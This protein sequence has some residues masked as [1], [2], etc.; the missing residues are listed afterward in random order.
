MKKKGSDRFRSDPIC[1][2][3]P[4]IEPQSQSIYSGLRL[5]H[6]DSKAR[7]SRLQPM[8]TRGP[9]RVTTQSVT[10]TKPATETYLQPT[11]P[12]IATRDSHLN[13]KSSA[14]DVA[15]SYRAMCYPAV[16]LALRLR[17]LPRLGLVLRLPQLIWLR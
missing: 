5:Q 11:Q 6:L 10:A 13:R 7:N 9:N 1:Y 12:E 2:L 17:G 16:K 4:K 15:H 8:Q 3:R 14:H